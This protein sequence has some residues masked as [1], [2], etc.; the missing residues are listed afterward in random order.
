MRDLLS[1]IYI[2]TLSYHIAAEK[3]TAARGGLS[4]LGDAGGE[5]CF[6]RGQRSRPPPR[7]VYSLWVTR[8][9]KAVSRA[10]GGTAEWTDRE[11]ARNLPR[12]EHASRKTAPCGCTRRLFLFCHSYRGDRAA[13]SALV[14][15][16]KETALQQAGALCVD[17]AGGQFVLHSGDGGFGL[18]A[19]HRE[20]G[21]GHP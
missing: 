21:A 14:V 18:N 1:G 7:A 8:E 17:K 2:I 4:A 6:A 11:S 13:F 12:G 10:D 15:D 3:S 9:E 16:V 19:Q 20:G 5:S